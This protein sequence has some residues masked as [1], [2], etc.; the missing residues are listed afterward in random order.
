MTKSNFSPQSV[1]TT[2]DPYAVLHIHRSASN[3]EIRSAWKKLIIKCH[4]DKVGDDGTAFR[5]VQT[6]YEMLQ[7]DSKKTPQQRAQAQRRREQQQR[8]KDFDRK[9]QDEQ[10]AAQRAYTEKMKEM[11]KARNERK[12]KEEEERK[13]KEQNERRIVKEGRNNYEE[14]MAR[15]R[16]DAYLERCRTW[17][18]QQAAKKKE[19]E[20]KRGASWAD[21]QQSRHNARFN[22]RLRRY[23]QQQ[24]EEPQEPERTGGSEEAAAA[25]AA[26]AG[27]ASP[28]TSPDP[29]AAGGSEAGGSEG[30]DSP[31]A[32]SEPAVAAKFAGDPKAVPVDEP[33]FF[34][35][36]RR[37]EVLN[38]L[39]AWLPPAFGPVPAIGGQ[40]ESMLFNR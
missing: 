16:H 26:A 27:A 38:G 37:K 4:P 18:E 15:E 8:R 3:A 25:G 7:A 33:S 36:H 5:R 6:A 10:A 22:S 17:N 1:E 23:M 40:R 13:E 39:H 32:R 29:S 30:S 19:Y 35:E 2:V 14:R 21:R 34:W 31:V 12:A 28:T 9:R 20:Q 24:E 11:E